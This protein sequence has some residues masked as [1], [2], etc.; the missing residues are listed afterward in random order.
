MLR[1]GIRPIAGT[2][3]IFAYLKKKGFDLDSHLSAS[4][5]AQCQSYIALIEEKLYDAL[6][7]N[8]WLDLD[9]FS[10]STRPVMV[11]SLSWVSRHYLPSQLRDRAK[12]RL[13]GYRMMLDHDGD[14]VNEVSD[15][16]KGPTLMR[17]SPTSLDAVAFGHLSMHAVPS[18]KNPRL[19]SL[20]T[21]EF[22][23]LIAYCD[24]L[25]QHL[26]EV[27]P[28]PSP[29][30]RPPNLLLHVARNPRV[31]ASWAYE[32]AGRWMSRIARDKP[33]E[34]KSEADASADGKKKE[35]TEKE[36]LVR[37]SR[38][39]AFYRA[40]SVVAGLGLF[41]GYIVYHGIVQIS[42]EEEEEE[43]DNGEDEMYNHIHE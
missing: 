9:N 14:L 23:T 32:S 27:P 15:D 36:E 6:L 35:Y 19:F 13:R 2:P 38:R 3:Y 12:E 8:R 41:I 16:A 18:I 28:R 11:H 22:P 10:D 1:D 17:N 30:V 29:N 31:Y 5:Y 37:A 21:F 20:L 33:A 26:F 24:R 40:M 43:D 34:Q 7:Y 42:V 25:K 39:D 4:E